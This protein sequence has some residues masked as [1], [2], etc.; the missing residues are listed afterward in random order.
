MHVG[1]FGYP[2]A[3]EARNVERELDGRAVEGPAAAL[4]G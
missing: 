1:L 3:V 2:S 4:R